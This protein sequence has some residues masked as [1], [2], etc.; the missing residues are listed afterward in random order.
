MK[1]QKFSISIQYKPK[2]HNTHK[3][4]VEKTEMSTLQLTIQ[5]FF[6]SD[7]HFNYLKLDYYFVRE[8]RDYT[9]YPL[10]NMVKYGLN[11]TMD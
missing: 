9:I 3:F 6:E 4:S 8:K 1:D 7:K 2:L 11:I 10:R 5:C